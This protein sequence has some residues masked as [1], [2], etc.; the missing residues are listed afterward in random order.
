MGSA[1]DF[2]LVS[3]TFE[4]NLMTDDNRSVPENLMWLSDF[5]GLYSFDNSTKPISVHRN[6][7]NLTI[8][9]N[10]YGQCTI[11]IPLAFATFESKKP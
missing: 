9:V 3:L 10:C 8:T 6:L 2:S 7:S 5:F 1:H 4:S 11:D